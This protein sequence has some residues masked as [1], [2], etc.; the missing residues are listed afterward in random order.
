M[1]CVYTK[2]HFAIEYCNDKSIH[3]V[4]NVT[5][6][7]LLLYVWNRIDNY[8]TDE[9]KKVLNEELLD[10][11]CKCFTGRLTRIVNSLNGFYDDVIIQISNN[12]Q[13]SNIIILIKSKLGKDYT[14][15]KHKELVCIE[16]N[17]RNYAKNIIDEW[18]SYI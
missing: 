3:I 13:I 6:E 1:I 5:F 15:E 11:M 16:L 18:V 4:L 9:I 7:E 17:E 8:K 10:A 14:E 2:F 12:E